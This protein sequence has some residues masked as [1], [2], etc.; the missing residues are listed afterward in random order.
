MRSPSGAMHRWPNS[1]GRSKTLCNGQTTEASTHLPPCRQCEQLVSVQALQCCTC[2]RGRPRTPAIACLSSRQKLCQ[3]T[4]PRMLTGSGATVQ[5]H[6]THGRTRGALPVQCN[7]MPQ[8]QATTD[9]YP[10]CMQ[11]HMCPV[12][13]KPG[14]QLRTGDVHTHTRH[15]GGQLG[16]CQPP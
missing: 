13:Q 14:R 5:S 6:K 16:C 12:S 8:L 4:N 15:N 10:A 9:R 7:C 2:Q 3:V 11:S 1:P